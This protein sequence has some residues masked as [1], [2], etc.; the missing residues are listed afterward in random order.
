MESQPKK[1]ASRV[2]LILLVLTLIGS[3]AIYWRLRHGVA[4]APG[5]GGFDPL[6][7]G[8]RA[9]VD[10]LATNPAAVEFRRLCRAKELAG[11]GKYAEALPIFEELV[12]SQPNTSYGWDADI[13][14][15][16]ALGH[17]G[18]Y[19][20]ALTRLDRIIATAPA[21]EERPL[22]MMAKAETYSIAG[23]HED[24][25]KLYQQ[26]IFEYKTR[27][28]FVCEG[29]LEELAREHAIKGEYGLARGAL[30]RLIEDFPGAEDTR[31]RAAQKQIEWLKDNVARQQKPRVAELAAGGKCKIVE[32]LER[33]QT[34]WRAEGGPYVVT[35][36]LRLGSGDLLRVEAG[37]LV[38]FTGEG[39]LVAADGRLEVI[40]TPEK[41]VQ[42]L[43]LGDDPGG[44]YWSGIS[45]ESDSSETACR[46]AY[47]Q[48]RGADP[49]LWLH[50][51]KAELDHCLFD[52]CGRFGVRA[53]DAAMLAMTSCEITGGYRVG[54]ECDGKAV[55]RAIDCRVSGQTIDGIILRYVAD[56]TAVERCIVEG[57]GG[58]GILTRGECRPRIE[59]C[60]IRKNEGAGVRTVEGASALI[61]DSKFEEN[62][63]AG[64]RLTENWEGELRGN[65]IAR[66]KAGGI[67]AESRCNGPITGS[68]IEAN[69]IVGVRLRLGCSPEITGNRILDNQGV[70]LLLENSQPAMLKGNEFSGNAEAALRNAS[71]GLVNAEG[72]WWGSAEES[73]V[74]KAIQGRQANP[75]WGEVQYRPWLTT[76][77]AK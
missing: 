9:G 43:P 26:I 68:T 28:P 10:V 38:R 71:E 56:E 32:K 41:P 34:D 39:G 31:R 19:D 58:D 18:R 14:A 25:V 63:D 50:R 61:V 47:C 48:V 49:G 74:A 5:A 24:A 60:Q 42:F 1:S 30:S 66:N 21:D 33:G 45:V 40:G 65:T 44:D 59:G 69:N 62:E 73:E 22:A 20:E 76:R 4:A 17:L 57:C 3:G 36:A 7:G 6:G 11:D 53:G 70:G 75:E 55:L 77:P 37:T 2:L 8:E 35:S 67:V 46:L 52:R 12:R 16:T 23:R 72:N 29:A 15:A 27:R 51:G 64:I 13:Q 54:L